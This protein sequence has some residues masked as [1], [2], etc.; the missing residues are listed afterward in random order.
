MAIEKR[1]E[2]EDDAISAEIPT[3]EDITA[4]EDGEGPAT[5]I[6]KNGFDSLTG[7]IRLLCNAVVSGATHGTSAI[8]NI[9]LQVEGMNVLTDYNFIASGEPKFLLDV[10]D[11]LA[12]GIFQGLKGHDAVTV[13]ISDV[14]FTPVTAKKAAPVS[15]VLPMLP[16]VVLP[17]TETADEPETT[18]LDPNVPVPL[19][20]LTA[21]TAFP[22]TLASLILPVALTPD[23]EY[24]DSIITE[25]TE[26]V[27]LTPDTDKFAVPTT[28][29]SPKP[30]VV[31]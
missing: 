13:P 4:M 3:S 2:L 28:D 15:V 14:P 31:A 22:I 7:K 20:P 9:R 30:V 19:I 27:A 25:P 21:K 17:E 29:S 1:I 6:G 26:V 12:D 23:T 10:N 18:V 16:V 11:G 5:L 24:P 8:D